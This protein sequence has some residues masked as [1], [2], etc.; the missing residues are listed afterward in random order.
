NLDEAIKL[1]DVVIYTP[2]LGSGV[3][4][5]AHCRAVCAFLYAD[6]FSAA[7]AHQLI[8]RVRNT[9]E[10]NV[11]LHGGTGQHDDNVRSIYEHALA[12]ARLTGQLA[13][14]DTH[15]IAIYTP[16]QRRLQGLLSRFQAVENT[17]KNNFKAHFVQLATGYRSVT[18]NED[19]LRDIRKQ[20]AAVKDTLAG[21][22]R[23]LVLDEDTM[24][25]EPAELEHLAHDGT[26]TRR[27][28]AGADRWRILYAA[29]HDTL[30]G[31]VYDALHLPAQRKALYQF[32]D[33]MHKNRRE[34]A[35]DDRDNAHV[36]LH[37]RR[38]Y[39]ART[40]ILRVIIRMLERA[41]VDMLAG[42]EADRAQITDVLAEH[43][44]TIAP[45]LRGL[46]GRRSDKSTDV[47]PLLRWLLARMGLKLT[48]RQIMRDGKRFRV[49]GIDGEQLTTWKA[50]A[51]SSRDAQLERRAAQ[52][53]TTEQQC[54]ITQNRDMDIKQ[55]PVLSNEPPPAADNLTARREY[56]F[57]C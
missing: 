56:V 5:Q 12:S 6:V 51:R 13:Q 55:L 46:F 22:W 20:L 11:Y 40:K 19:N 1:Y 25:V 3:D 35:A 29:G 57:L 47:I 9:E 52:N 4:I 53:A 39:T 43:F 14:Y 45:Q 17:S 21:E 30:T 24:P 27:D 18:V 32:R 28:R 54:G 50:L 34:L 37:H 41:G 31:E 16:Q 36:D 42:D 23:A 7:D 33:V 44:D 26:L 8:N 38:H 10:V 2:T 49:Y 15:G 48:S